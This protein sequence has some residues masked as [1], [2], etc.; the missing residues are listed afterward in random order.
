MWINVVSYYVLTLPI[1]YFAAFKSPPSFLGAKDDP[2]TGLNGIW[3]AFIVGYV[4]QCL[5]YLALVLLTDW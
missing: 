1:I 3:F 4:H 2:D 5:A